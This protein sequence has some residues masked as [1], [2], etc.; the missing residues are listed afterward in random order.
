MYAVSVENERNILNPVSI[1]FEERQQQIEEEKQRE[2]KEQE[3]NK[4]SPYT[5]WVQINKDAYKAEDWLMGKSPI[6]Y[7]IFKFL[8]NN[9]DGYNAVVCSYQVLQECFSIS[10]PTVTRAIKLLKE[11]QYV[12]VH[13]SGT[14]NVYTVNKQLAWNSW[15][16]NYKYAK[17]SAN[18]IISEGEQAEV[19]AVKHKEIKLKHE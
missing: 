3:Q 8:I 4:K 9:M 7:R 19:K 5:S 13:K 11:K 2:K 17:F 6:A 10:K 15:G 16:S 1:T 14:T 18:I 12:D